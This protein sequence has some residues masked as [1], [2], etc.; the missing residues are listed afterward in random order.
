MKAVVCTLSAWAA[1]VLTAHAGEATYARFQLTDLDL[2]DPHVFVD[3]LGCRD[4]TDTAIL[5]FSVNGSLA[6]S[7]Q[8]DGDGDGF[9]DQSYVIQFTPLDR[10]A[11]SSTMAVGAAQ[12]TAPLEGSQCGSLQNPQP[13][14][15]ALGSTAACLA[16]LQG[17]VRP[18]SPAVTASGPPCFASAP[19]SLTFQLFDTP[20]LLSN[21]QVGARF[22]D[23][24]GT[25]LVDGLV[26]GFLS[27]EVARS[28]LIPDSVPLVGGRTLAQVLPGGSGPGGTNPNC[29]A[30]D[31]RDMIN[32]EIGWWFYFNFPAQRIADL[33]KVLH[34]DSFEDAAE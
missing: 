24:P 33:P 15:A 5:G 28:T 7:L 11:T 4:V 29:A 14:N 23:A 19:V 34:A 18:Y 26:R 25:G 17:T 31:D 10:S 16:A 8:T 30:H 3:F 2:R 27:E 20:V 12:C 1:A 32:L 9:L 13:A 21:A 22:A 6:S